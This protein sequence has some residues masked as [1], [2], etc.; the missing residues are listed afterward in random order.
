M[1]AE[2]AQRSKRLGVES[3]QSRVAAR[4]IVPGSARVRMTWCLWARRLKR[5]L[6]YN[7]FKEDK[8]P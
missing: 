6:D 4:K 3:G 5:F 1:D 2:V 8:S 7:S